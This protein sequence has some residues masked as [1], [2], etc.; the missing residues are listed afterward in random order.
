MDASSVLGPTSHGL[1]ALVA[2]SLGASVAQAQPAGESQRWI[3]AAQA[4]RP[5]VIAT[6][7]GEIDDRCSMVRFLLYT[8][9][10][11]VRGIIHSSSCYHWMGDADHPAKDWADV[12]WLDRQ[13]DAYAEVYPNLVR[14]DPGYPTP[15]YLRGQVRLGNVAYE[16]DMSAP[17]PGSDRIVEV[18]LDPDPSPVWLLA[19]GGVNTIARALKSIEEDHPEHVASVA[20]KA[21]V[22]LIAEQDRV[23]RDYLLPRWPDV[24]Y[25]LCNA[26][27]AI[28]YDWQRIMSPEEQAYF[29]AT[30]MRANILEDH[31][32]LCALYEA[33]G[34][35]RFMSEGDSPA[36]LHLV[37]CGLRAEVDP[38]WGGWGG[39]FERREGWW[40]STPADHDAILRW[41]P[42]LQ[43]DWASRADWCVTAPDE[44]NHRPVA[45]LNGDS[46]GAA[47]ALSV[48]P[49]EEV[50]LSASGSTDPDGN[51]LA[52]RWWTLHPAG[53]YWADMPVADPLSPEAV[54]RIP[55]DAAGRTTHVIL[56]VTDEGDPPLTSY[57]RVVL[58]VSGQPEPSPRERYLTTPITELPGPPA[59]SGPWRFFRGYN[60]GGGAVVIDGN[61]WAADGA[62]EVS[63]PP[64][65]LDLPDIPL[66]PPTDDERASMIHSFRWGNPATVVISDVPPATYAVYVYVWED[67]D[68]EGLT[69]S[70]E[71]QVVQ[72]RHASGEKGEWHRLGPWV[73]EITDG[74]IEI[75]GTGG[76]AN[77][78][79]IELWQRTP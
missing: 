48:D 60:L 19:W 2:L 37:D 56:E 49:G 36:F 4:G 70:I 20:A 69:F 52:F 3:G 7:D 31:G 27:G 58:E 1:I 67:N 28:A 30:W 75:T 24:E 38:S 59:D 47:L 73:A 5:R 39:R 42:S 62:P 21:R 34:D 22:F 32:P 63:A 15:D 46:S 43:R 74:A 18:L 12:S 68:S 78:S 33:H 8:N 57:R 53:D 55:A 23:F 6:T 50:R 35:G 11:D 61:A 72:R 10:W 76:A 51:A 79:G 41:A 71:G 25:L 77:L 45:V 54:I 13:L 26:Y 40:E 9:E 64:S 44:A 29:G 17:S 14:H 65:V 16:G 66:L